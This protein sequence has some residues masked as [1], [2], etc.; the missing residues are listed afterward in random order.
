MIYVWCV[1]SQRGVVM[2]LPWTDAK[3]EMLKALSERE[4][5]LGSPVVVCRWRIRRGTATVAS[6]SKKKGDDGDDVGVD[7]L[8][9][10][11]SALLALP[12][13]DY[14]IELGRA[15]SIVGSSTFDLVSQGISWDPAGTSTQ[16]WMTAQYR[17]MAEESMRMAGKTTEEAT[18][19]RKEMQE[20]LIK[21]ATMQTNIADS[22]PALL[23]SA[24]QVN[25][26]VAETIT[27]SAKL[28]MAANQEAAAAATEKA[29]NGFWA[30][31]MAELK[32]DIIKEGREL[33][34]TLR[35][36]L[37]LGVDLGRMFVGRLLPG[38]K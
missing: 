19:M 12:A 4:R 34:P 33:M 25:T 18:A 27:A 2:I 20:L 16:M 9:E 28:Y 30:L 23:T 10:A 37:G 32:D 15:R 31:V 22:I 24:R 35:G 5:E 21:M 14:T 11:D 26:E 1:Y 8:I 6:G 7:W 13:S 36:L 17:Q 38:G 29:K 3:K